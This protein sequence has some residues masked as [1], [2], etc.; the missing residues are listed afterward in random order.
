MAFRTE[1]DS[2]RPQ[3]QQRADN[4][5][6]RLSRDV[7]LKLR[8]GS[9]RAAPPTSRFFLKVSRAGKRS[10][11]G[12]KQGR[13][14]IPLVGP[15]QFLLPVLRLLPIPVRPGLRLEPGDDTACQQGRNEN[16]NEQAAQRMVAR[17]T[18]VQAA[19]KISGRA[20]WVE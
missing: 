20:W 4:T 14:K 3:G 9:L 17:G 7:P 19:F 10:F 11:P 1:G 5:G 15:C 8:Q 13:P 2:M 18:G 16:G 12:W 6:Y